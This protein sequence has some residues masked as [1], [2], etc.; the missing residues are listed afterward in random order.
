[1]LNEQLRSY[2]KRAKEA[3][4]RLLAADRQ[5]AGLKDAM[6]ANAD[7]AAAAAA[8]K[9]AAAAAAAAESRVAQLEKEARRRHRPQPPRC[10]C[11]THL[12][13]APVA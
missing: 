7:S 8:A 1:M 5:L 10:A 12:S 6:A 3:E 11:S 4:A 13:L 2:R 9:K